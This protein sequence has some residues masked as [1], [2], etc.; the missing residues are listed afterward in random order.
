MLGRVSMT[1]LYAARSPQDTRR[2]SVPPSLS[3]VVLPG[4]RRPG[5][6]ED[7]FDQ[8]WID[9]LAAHAVGQ[10]E[11][12]ALL[13]LDADEDV[14][15]PII[16]P[17]FIEGRSVRTLEQHRAQPGGETDLLVRGIGFRLQGG[18]LMR[19]GDRDLRPEHLGP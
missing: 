4:P 3:R 15:G 12:A 14:V 8:G 10:Q 5:V 11:D 18:K 2:P 7:G 19:R 9:G 17:A 16:V 13:R 6:A 1:S